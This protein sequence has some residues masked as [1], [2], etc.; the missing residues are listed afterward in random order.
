MNRDN[1]RRTPAPRRTMP[2]YQPAPYTGDGL[3]C[4]ARLDPNTSKRR[5]LD[6]AAWHE[7][8]H[9]RASRHRVIAS[10]LREAAR[11]AVR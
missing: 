7:S 11:A 4:I 9:R 10:V 8:P 1:T 3:E 2:S 6:V 5:L